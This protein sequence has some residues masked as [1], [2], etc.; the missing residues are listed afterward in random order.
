MRLCRTARTLERSYGRDG[1]EFLQ[2]VQMGQQAQLGEGV[3]FQAAMYN[4]PEGSAT[5]C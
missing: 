4:K 2:R 5:V 1:V 3:L